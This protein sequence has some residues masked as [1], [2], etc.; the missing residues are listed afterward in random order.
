MAAFAMK[1]LTLW[2]RGLGLLLLLAGVADLTAAET[3]GAH[4]G[5]EHDEHHAHG[6]DGGGLSVWWVLPFAGMLLSIALG[7]LVA[8]HF[9][10]SHYGKVAAGWIAVFAV[11]FLASFGG[12][13]FYEILHIVLL[14]YV[15]F[16]IL[17]TALFTAAGGIC[18]KGSLRGSPM[19]NTAILLIGTVLASWMGTTGAAMLLI[20]PILRANAW[21]KHRVHV[22]VFFIF[23]VANI[24]G[25]LTPLG[26]PPL[27]LGFLKGVDFFWTMKLLPVMAPVSVALLIIFFIVDTLMF[28]KEGEAPDDGEKVPL[29]LEG[30]L[31]FAMVGLIIGAILFS[32]SLGDGKFKDAS[33]AEKMNPKIEAA[34]VVMG[35]KKTVLVDFVKAHEGETFDESNAAYHTARVEHLHSIADVNKLR[36]QKTHDEATGVHIFG[37]TVPYSNLVR[38]GLLI[39]IVFISLRITP[40][41]RVQKDEHGHEVAAE[42]EEETNVRAA[43]GFTWEPI[44]EVAKLFVAIFVCMIPALLILKAGVDGGLKSVILM[45][46]TSTNEP[47]NAMYFWLT[48]MLSSFLDNAPTYVVFFNTA[49]GD[50]TSLMGEGGMF[51]LSVGTT[52]LAISCGAVF[53]GAN[54]YIGNAPNFMVKAI[55]EENGVKMPSFFGYMAWSAAILIPVFIVVSLLYF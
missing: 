10:H 32:K 30:A 17:L 47:I 24:G 22:V 12:D 23:L 46:Q 50:P 28:R 27:F 42:G 29:K 49:G 38:D 20:R 26:D 9:W 1:N 39:L 31:N 2:M 41:Y 25:S 14:D 21:R 43:N 55:A 8:A 44:L 4:A 37:V 36:A 18:L 15:P 53:M 45:V 7:P 13:A 54:T 40:M 35:E 34:E 16:I 11:P 33:V 19:V 6:V 5:H 52:L 51:D 48:G 3:E